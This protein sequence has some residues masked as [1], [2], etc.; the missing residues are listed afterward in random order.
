V[1]VFH[2]LYD[3]AANN[4]MTPLRFHSS[5]AEPLCSG[6]ALVADSAMRDHIRYGLDQVLAGLASSE[7]GNSWR[8]KTSSR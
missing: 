5:L 7:H 3:N 8:L 4:N 2:W 1:L 6:D